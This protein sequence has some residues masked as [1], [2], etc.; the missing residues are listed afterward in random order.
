MVKQRGTVPRGHLAQTLSRLI[1]PRGKFATVQNVRGRGRTRWPAPD[2]AHLEPDSK[3]Q[4][5][6]VSTLKPY[7]VQNSVGLRLPEVVLH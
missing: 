7:S 6:R 3:A 4:L 5:C 2:A 1:K